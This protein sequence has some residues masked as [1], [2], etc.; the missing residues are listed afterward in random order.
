MASETQ[1]TVEFPSALSRYFFSKKS[2]GLSYKDTL[3]KNKQGKRPSEQELENLYNESATLR[4]FYN[5]P[6]TLPKHMHH[7]QAR[8]PGT[9][10]QLDVMDMRHEKATKAPL[11]LIAIC[12][13]SRFCNVQP[14][15][16]KGHE[17][18]IAAMKRFWKV[19]R[20][21]ENFPSQRKH[22]YLTD[23]GKMPAHHCLLLLLLT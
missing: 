15:L 1:G 18:M 5:V 22:Q 8:A 16:N 23:A 9:T 2:G 12:C 6:R 10:Y 11:A 19:V 4:R 14:L 17:E 7:V 21:F 20:P 3:K 13:Y